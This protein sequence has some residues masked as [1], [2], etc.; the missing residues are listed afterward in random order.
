M[1]C[2]RQRASYGKWCHHSVSW[3]FHIR[4]ENI[5]IAYILYNLIAWL[6]Y[7]II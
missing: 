4:H 1:M 6:I 2:R 7:F 5:Y 3:T